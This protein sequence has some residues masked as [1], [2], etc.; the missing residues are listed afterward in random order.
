MMFRR[1]FSQQGASQMRNMLRKFAVVA[2]GAVAMMILSAVPA[3]AST[4][5]SAIGTTIAY[6]SPTPYSGMVGGYWNGTSLAM[7]CWTDNV[8]S[9]G[10]NRWFLVG[11]TGFD[12]YSGL[13][14]FLVGFVSANKVSHQVRVGHC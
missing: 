14:E 11:G 6:D 4:P 1:A 3:F 9:N 5:P 13:P 7:Y 2:F 8:W 10:T 12:P